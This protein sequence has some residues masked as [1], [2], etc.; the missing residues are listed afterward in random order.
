M[1]YIEQDQKDRINNA[2]FELYEYFGK[3]YDLTPGQFNYV[4]TQL[5]LEYLDRKGMSYTTLNEIN[6]VLDS[7]A[8]EFYRRVVVPYEDKKRE[9]NGDVY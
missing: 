5:C 9:E 8:K 7:V 3:G 1:P 6:G 4:V 2:A